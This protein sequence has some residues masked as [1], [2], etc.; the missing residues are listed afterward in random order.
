MPAPIAPGG[1]CESTP[2]NRSKTV[3]LWRLSIYLLLA[4]FSLAGAAQPALAGPSGRP[5]KG[6][7]PE[8]F[9]APPRSWTPSASPPSEPA[10]T[11]KLSADAHATLARRFNDWTGRWYGRM[12]EVRCLGTEHAP[13]PET[14][15]Y[16]VQAD[17]HQ[18]ISDRLVFDAQLDAVDQ[19]IR[20]HVRLWWLLTRHY[21]RFGDERTAVPDAPR[22][23]VDVI[24]ISANG[25]TFRRWYRVRPRPG[26]SLA[27]LEVRA[28]HGD[29][30]SLI[31]R[32]A[33]Y[34]QGVLTG[35]RTWRLQKGA[36]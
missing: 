31:I 10:G 13:R 30:R 27:R 22:W 11:G 1:R 12:T 4:A 15:H 25:F 16:R 21:L 5:L 35:R 33:F 26:R 24:N 32:E 34:T 7:A 23:N 3:N 20:R 8:C 18:E 9:S 29:R 17:L 28:L 6:L 14:T 19:G 36:G 2:E